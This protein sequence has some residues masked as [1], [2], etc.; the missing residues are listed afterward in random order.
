MTRMSDWEMKPKI[1]ATLV[2]FGLAVL[3]LT[4]LFGWAIWRKQWG[5]SPRLPDCRTGRSATS[6][7]GPTTAAT[8]PAG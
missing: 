3:V 2:S 1:W 4:G 6:A 5:P 8:R 7:W